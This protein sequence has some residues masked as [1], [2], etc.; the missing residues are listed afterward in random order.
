M[1]RKRGSR[2]R[3]LL[4]ILNLLNLLSHNPT[5]YTMP[6]LIARLR[7]TR[8]TL[9]R[10][11]EALAAS[12]IF[13]EREEMPTREVRYKLPHEYRFVKTTF[14]ENELFSLFFA[15]NLLKPLEG[16]PFG[17]GIESALDKIYKLLPAEVQNYCFFTESYFVFRQPFLRS[18]KEFEANIRA[19]KDAILR[20]RVC[21]IEYHKEERTDRHT[22]H[23]YFVTYVDGLLYVIAY[24]EQRRE[25]RTFRVDRIERVRVLPKTFERPADFR[26]ENFDPERILGR[27]LK[28]YGDETIHPVVISFPREMAERI[29][30]RTWHASQKIEAG[31]GGR[32]VLSMELPITPEVTSW[33]LS[34]GAQARVLKPPRL[35]AEVSRA[36]R[37]AARQYA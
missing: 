21:E 26:S 13:L 16:T 2:N 35:V 19:L 28:I 32:V 36:L 15:K 29:R 10:D 22:I 9:Y 30:E 20:D 34:F 6:E 12:G 31:R 14:D 18:Y 33:V 25:K 24:S 11:L 27:T 8:R 17:R 5:G 1:G 37:Q 4:R 7:A 23:P 3:Q